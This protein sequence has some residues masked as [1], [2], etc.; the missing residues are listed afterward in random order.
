MSYFDYIHS[1]ISPDVSIWHTNSSYHANDVV[2]RE[3]EITGPCAVFPN[4]NNSVAA[5]F[6]GD[7]MYKET[8]IGTCGLASTAGSRALFLNHYGTC[9]PPSIGSVQ[10]IQ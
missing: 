1:R 8:A 10:T 7:G 3:S 5:I 4:T 2:T 6:G 9:F